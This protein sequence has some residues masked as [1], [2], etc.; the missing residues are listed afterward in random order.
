MKR[1]KIMKSMKSMKSVMLLTK[2][3]P[4]NIAKL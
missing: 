1:I 3:Y 4:L 2:S